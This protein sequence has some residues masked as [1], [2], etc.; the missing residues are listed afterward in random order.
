MASKS[1]VFEYDVVPFTSVDLGTPVVQIVEMNDGYQI[2]LAGKDCERIHESESQWDRGGIQVNEFAS[3]RDLLVE[4]M[5]AKLE[6]D[7][8]VFEDDTL[9]DV[10]KRM[11][12]D[13]DPVMGGGLIMVKRIRG[14]YRDPETLFMSFFD[15]DSDDDD[16]DE[17]V[18][19]EED[20]A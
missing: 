20:C 15:G 12:E 2:I 7:Q 16:E 14:G 5:G 10:L 6:G 1:S 8:L 9:E 13:E 17:G 19:C 3:L 18:L 11:T 4:E